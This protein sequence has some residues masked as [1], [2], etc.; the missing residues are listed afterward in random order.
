RQSS[1][2]S[3][4]ARR[5]RDGSIMPLILAIEPDRRQANQVNAVVRGRL[6]A[7][8]VLADTA[9]RALATLGNRVPD[10]ILTAALLSPNDESVLAEH[11]RGLGDAAAHIQTLT[12]P[13]LASRSQSEEESGG[14]MLSA[15]RRKAKGSV[16][17]GCDPAVFA[18][19]CSE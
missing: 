14:G 4:C 1:C 10:L 17:D 13:V 12:I 6:H 16:P 18:Q 3:C 9:E 15:L 5:A 19:Q 8:L 11:L 7:E 2:S